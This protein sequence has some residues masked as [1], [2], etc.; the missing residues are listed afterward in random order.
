M[1]LSAKRIASLS[2]KGKP[3]RHA[4]GHGLYLV[5]TGVGTG[6]WQF[7]YERDG[8]ERWM[9][10]GP[11]DTISLAEARESAL[12]ARKQLLAGSDPIQARQEARARAAAVKRITF[13]EAAQAYYDLHER[14]WK[15]PKHRKQFLST[16]RQYAFPVLGSLPV[17]AIDTGA[18]LR[19]IEP[20]W[21]SK[22][23]TASRVRQRIEKVL[24][25][26]IVRGYRMPPNPAAWVGHL[27]EAMPDRSAV[28]KRQNHPALPYPELPAFMAALRTRT[29]FAS[30]ALEFLILTAARTGEVIGARWDDEIDL[31]N[32]TWTVPAERMKAG[33]V[34]R[35]PLSAPALALLR[36]LPREINN[37]F[38]FPGLRAGTGLSPAAMVMVLKHME[39]QQITVHGM[40][41]TFRTWCD[42]TTA[43]PH[44]VTEQAL[45]HTIGSGVERAYRRGDL[46]DKRRKLMNA[47]ASY[48]TSPPVQAADVVPLRAVQS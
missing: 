7:R 19:A 42:E 23:E 15:N 43:F 22:T 24:S 25:W 17:D 21:L 30:R 28:Q 40:R 34:H 45:A 1:R 47:W 13:K 39:Y 14:S 41:S 38:V 5:V 12:V 2:K 29:G 4:D 44:H 11:T 46:F 9:G 10:L 36:A 27:R 18:V 33:K 31:D 20:I 35:V 3:D 16:L 32:A 8:R 6:N 37:N 26:S 48:A